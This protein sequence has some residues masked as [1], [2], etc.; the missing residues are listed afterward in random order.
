MGKT[1]ILFPQMITNILITSFLIAYAH[2]C[3]SQLFQSIICSNRILKGKSVDFSMSINAIYVEKCPTQAFY[4][5]S[6]NR[7]NTNVLNWKIISAFSFDIMLRRTCILLFIYAVGFLANP[8]KAAATYDATIDKALE[9]SNVESA[10]ENLYEKQQKYHGSTTN[11]LLDLQQEIAQ[12]LDKN[13]RTNNNGFR[14][15]VSGRERCNFIIQNQERL[16]SKNRIQKLINDMLNNGRSTI[17]GAVGDYT[18]V[19]ESF[20]QLKDKTKTIKENLIAE[21]KHLNEQFDEYERNRTQ[22]NIELPQRRAGAVKEFADCEARKREAEQRNDE[23]RRRQRQPFQQLQ[24]AQQPQQPQQEEIVSCEA[25]ANEKIK[26]ERT[27]EMPSKEQKRQKLNE[28]YDA[29][30]PALDNLVNGIESTNTAIEN[31]KKFISKLKAMA[32]DPIYTSNDST[33][34]QI[35][36]NL[37]KLAPKLDEYVKRHSGGAILDFDTSSI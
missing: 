18:K 8:I 7:I 34:Q 28:V 32:T 11:D 36:D 13:R 9:S 12:L 10:V 26:L 1:H 4:K 16:A 21:R 31:E 23:L 29:L 2:S 15:A 30:L 35:V 17:D 5:T 14:W 37:K 33:Q 6:L 20:D 25:Q 24:R 27:V 22:F 19:Q 3:A